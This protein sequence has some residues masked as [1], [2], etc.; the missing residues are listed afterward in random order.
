MNGEWQAIIR[1]VNGDTMKFKKIA[2]IGMGLIGGS[3]GKAVIEN[4]LADEVIGICRRQVSLD[5][6]IKEKALTC[7]FIN[8]Y[9]EALQG[10]EIVII[11][12]PVYT[13]KTALKEIAGVI[14]DKKVIVTDV[15]STKKEIVEYAEKF[16]D[17]FSF[18]GGHPL[19][20]SEKAGVEYSTADLYKGSV[21]VLTPSTGVLSEDEKKIKVLWESLGAKVG[22]LDPEE[23]DKALAFSSHLPHIAAYA[24]AG[25]LEEKFPK[26]TYTT[27]F[28]D[29]TRI[30]SSDPKIWSDIF[31]SN[32]NNVLNAIEK[33]K[34]ILSDIEEK[35]KE[36][37]IEALKEKLDEYKRLRD[38]LV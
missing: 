32:N 31:A 11:A 1:L 22:I 15:G 6:A 23:H 4:N 24:L 13:I 7:G 36:N 37:D 5:K 19:A 27:G 28:K 21:C 20:G 38:E 30:A 9:E 25:T 17:R 12:T 29:T 34:K 35:I 3:I 2:I 18:I 16:K 8:N 10:A 26:T 14:N 33:Y